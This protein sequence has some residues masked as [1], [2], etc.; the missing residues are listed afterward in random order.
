[1]TIE[2][3]KYKIDNKIRENTIYIHT[4]WSVEK[5]KKYV[6]AFLN[7]HGGVL[8]FGVKDDGLNLLV[9]NSVFDILSSYKNIMQEFSAKD[10]IQYGQML[11]DNHN[12][13][14]IE[15]EKS[16]EEYSCNGTIYYFD[17]RK[18][19]PIEKTSIT[20]FLSYCQKDKGIA[21]I[22]EEKLKENE[23][24][25]EI[26]RD[27]REVGYRDKFSEFMQTISDKD[28]VL[29]II[30]DR[31]LKSRNCMYE[32]SE[33]MRDRKYENKLLFIVVSDSDKKYYL[34]EDLP[35]DEKQGVGAH[36]YDVYQQ[37]EY[38]MYWQEK[39]QQLT[40]IIEKIND[41][42]ISANQIK[43]LEIVKTIEL[44]IRDLMGVLFDRK[45][46]SFEEMIDTNFI[47]VINIIKNKK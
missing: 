19:E 45:G 46:I 21:N 22:V 40:N 23:K 47:D 11:M 5:L 39:E 33:L 6:C 24:R 25:L 10:S 30:S 43:E 29:S 3:L 26:S 31:Y 27:I 37:T 12:I 44:K 9:K 41:P 34:S 32:M 17:N 8:I 42:I 15:V 18:R 28:F 2:D 16:S 36:I 14:Y 13:E 4:N 7:T 35:N 20:M 1:M 38:I